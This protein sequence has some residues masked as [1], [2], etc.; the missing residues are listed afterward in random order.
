MPMDGKGLG[1]LRE[2]SNKRPLILETGKTGESRW[3]ASKGH[4]IPGMPGK[5]RERENTKQKLKLERKIFGR[6][7]Y[8]IV[9]SRSLCEG[10]S[11][12]VAASRIRKT[13]G[14]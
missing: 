9:V 3:I 12:T 8:V 10:E 6:Y 11:V 13:S 4:E 2:H 1:W 14:R 5:P 7:R